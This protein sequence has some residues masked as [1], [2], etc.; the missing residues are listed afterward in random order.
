VQDGLEL[1]GQLRQRFGQD[2]LYLLGHSWGTFLGIWIAQQRPEWFA[3]YVG[4]GQM[5]S[6]AQNDPMQYAWTLE[7]A[8]Q[9]GDTKVVKT[10]ERDGPPPYRGGAVRVARKYAHT[11][12]PNFRYMAQDL[13]AAGGT[14]RGGDIATMV[15]TPEYRPVDKL[16]AVAGVALTFGVVYPQLDR[17]DLAT[18]VPELAV[19]VYLVEGRYDT[20]AMP[21]LAQRYL[22]EV[23]APHKELVWFEHSGHNPCFEEADRFNHFMVDTVLEETRAASDASFQVQRS[24]QAPARTR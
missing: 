22:Q 9:N 14:L 5:V 1:T 8:R 7:R 18:Q 16:F 17:V 6:P 24:I 10:L 23:R 13:R 15:N 4:V 19:P 20:N 3:A 2:K 11:T 12:F 21:V